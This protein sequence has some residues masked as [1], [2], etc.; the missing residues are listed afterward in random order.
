MRDA[1][2]KKGMGA[3]L[4]LTL[5]VFSCPE[6][7]LAA[8]AIREIRIEGNERVDRSTIERSLALKMGDPFSEAFA[9]LS[10]KQLYRLGAFSRVSLETEDVGEDVVLIVRVREFPMIRDII[11][12]GNEAVQEQD[13]KKALKM[14]TFSFYDPGKLNE[15]IE[16]LLGVYRAEGY[17]E[18]VITADAEETERGVVLTYRI[19]ESEKDLVLEIDIIGNRALDDSA[20][21]KVMQLKEK[22]P[23]S[24]I[25]GGGGYDDTL[26]ADDIKRIK[27]LYMENGYLDVAVEE[28]HVRIHPDGEGIYI[29]IQVHEGP[30]YSLG[31]VRFSGDWDESPD[32]AR[33]ESSVKKGD[34]F[35]RSQV[36]KDVLMYENSYRDQGYAWVR[37]EPLFSMDSEAGTI[38]LNMVLKRG[39]LVHIRWINISGNYKTRDYVIRREMRLVE[40]EQFSQ[41]KLDDSRKFIRALGFFETVNIGLSKAGENLAD[42]NVQVKEGT[43]GS[44]SAGLAY[45]SVSGLVGTLQLSLG[46]FGGRGQRL[47]LNVEVGSETST[48]SIDFIEPRLFSGNYSFGLNLFDKVNEYSTYTQDSIGGSVRLGYRLSDE[49]SVSM[50]YRYVEYNVYDITQDASLIIQEQEGEN[51]TSSVRLGY[52]YDTRDFPMDPREGEDVRIYGEFA[53]EF[54]GGTND[55]VRFQVEGSLFRPISGDL[56]GLAHAEVGLINSFGGDDIP[57]T[58]RFFMGGLYTLRGFEYRKVGPLEDGEPVGGAKSFLVNMEAT[59]PLIRDAN[60][61]GVLFLDAGNVWADEE[62]M[63]LDELR[64]GAGFGF[65]WAAPIGLLRLE[66]GFNLDPRPEEDQPGWE[67]SIGALF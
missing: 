9:T 12:T 35:V 23:L 13:L 51:T 61:K 48:Y 22:G 27:F 44:L 65:R 15:E 34:V 8:S 47:N 21:T 63:D 14:K 55:F 24:F 25:S 46:N 45:S 18:T 62:K 43:A 39:P 30:K 67:F 57:V 6:S 50:R 2:L 17:H 59:Y 31:E 66:W 42:I 53:G 32:F 36:L 54:L 4:L 10:I 41:V 26:V 60:I 58:E 28:P 33:R 3:L 16:T 52:H 5:S 29:S 37:I 7:A 20:V 11:M 38:S 64:Y 19:E 49:T 1:V 56:I 40:G